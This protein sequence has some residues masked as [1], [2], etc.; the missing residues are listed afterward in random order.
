MG[1]GDHSSGGPL[2]LRK[3]SA[4]EFDWMNLITDWQT[5]PPEGVPAPPNHDEDGRPVTV[6][7]PSAEFVITDE[8]GHKFR[9]PL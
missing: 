4:M 5:V 8:Q 1:V 2:S 6:D 3:E 7:Q 9:Y